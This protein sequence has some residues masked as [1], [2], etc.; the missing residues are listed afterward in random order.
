MNNYPVEAELLFYVVG[1]M[2]KQTNTYDKAQ[3]RSLQFC[4]H[5]PKNTFSLL[6]INTPSFRS[7]S[8]HIFI[9]L[10]LMRTL[11]Q[12]WSSA[13]WNFLFLEMD[14]TD[15]EEHAAS[16]CMDEVT[17]VRIYSK[18]MC[19]RWQGIW[20]PRTIA[21]GKQGPYPSQYKLYNRTMKN[22]FYMNGQVIKIEQWN[23]TVTATWHGYW[24]LRCMVNRGDW[25]LSLLVR[26]VSWINS[27]KLPFHTT[28]KRMPC[29]WAEHSSVSS[30]C[31]EQ[32]SLTCSRRICPA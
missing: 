28:M 19:A 21:K 16:I 29:P 23:L 31:E 12:L 24:T 14:T 26:M 17:K 13:L 22:C 27:K 18:A 30:R 10:I 25:S 20:L 15:L 4:E 1:Q 9:C 7:Y 8:N 32:A 6:R 3:R 5:M 11:F 2:D